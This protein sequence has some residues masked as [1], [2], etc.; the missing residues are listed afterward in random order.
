VSG[1][2]VYF[3][4]ILKGKYESGAPE[5]HAWIGGQHGLR[6]IPMRIIAI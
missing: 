5:L 4:W 2:C 1:T 6:Y 3:V